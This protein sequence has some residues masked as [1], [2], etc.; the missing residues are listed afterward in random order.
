M[1]DQHVWPGMVKLWSVESQIPS[2]QKTARALI[3]DL[4]YKTE[5]W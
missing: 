5:T 1:T 4:E 2:R 3:N